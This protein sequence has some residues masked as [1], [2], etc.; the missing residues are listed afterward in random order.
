MYRLIIGVVW[1][2]Y[3]SLDSAVRDCIELIPDADFSLWND[4]QAEVWQDVFESHTNK[5]IV[6]K[7]I[8]LP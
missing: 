1:E 7:I 8:E 6:G 3:P 2:D 5:T 4:S